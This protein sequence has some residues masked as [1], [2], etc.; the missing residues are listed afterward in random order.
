MAVWLLAGLVVLALFQ[1]FVLFPALF[2]RG[3]SRGETAAP[4]G[5]LPRRM[6]RIFR[7]EGD[8]DLILKTSFDLPAA[9]EA[10]RAALD[11]RLFPSGPPHRYVLLEALNRT[12]KAVVLDLRKD[13][14]ILVDR[15]GRRFAP[16]DLGPVLRER[17]GKLPAYLAVWLSTRVP[18]EGRLA[19]GPGRRGTAL[20]AYSAEATLPDLAEV[21]IGAR[22]LVPRSIRKDELDGLL[23]GAERG[24]G[25]RRR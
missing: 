13:P 6:L 22:T 15:S 7:R 17:A 10:E 25:G 1:G 4:A 11:G 9:D 3:E 18:R 5:G 12:E 8:L 16:V 23:S 19:V 24:G 14:V 21:R 2:P 20:L